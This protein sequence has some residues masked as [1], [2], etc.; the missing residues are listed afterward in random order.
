[1]KRVVFKT[2]GAVAHR[3]GA[4]EAGNHFKNVAIL[5]NHTSKNQFLSCVVVALFAV[6]AAFASC[7]KKN[8]IVKL[9]NII[10]YS[11]DG[12][13]TFEYDSLNRITKISRYNKD[14]KPWYIQTLTYTGSD[15]VKYV[16]TYSESDETETE[17]YTK[18][19]NQITIEYENMLESGDRI[20]DL[21]T[22][23]YPTKYEGWNN[24]LSFV[25]T[26]TIQND[27][28]TK[29]TTV[30]HCNNWDEVKK[31]GSINYRYDDKK[32]PFT[33]CATPKWWMQVQYW[34]IW[35]FNWMTDDYGSKNNVIEESW[36]NAS[37]Y[38]RGDGFN[39][40]VEYKYEY[41]ND[42]Y[43]I[44]RTGGGDVI[45]FQYKQPSKRK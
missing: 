23:G 40:K 10:T 43:P 29:I 7:D 31:E 26:S 45:T 11:D 44:K 35:T 17:E 12:Y 5:K 36:N 37:L 41:D 20:L 38:S 3:S 22:E 27:N 33:H 25:Y 21:N 28:V 24:D 42:G 34:T 2:S 18:K 1:M 15:L 8:D 30:Q 13:E 9:P 4:M 14:E 6:S 32:S 39:G 19:G 16:R